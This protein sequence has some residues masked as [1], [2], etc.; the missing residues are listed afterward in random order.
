MAAS[1]DP[2]LTYTPLPEIPKI[3]SKARQVFESN[4]TLPISFRKAQ[5]RALHRCVVDNTDAFAQAVHKD[6]GKPPTEVQL[7][8]IAG[9]LK[10]AAEMHDKL[11]TLAKDEYVKVDLINAY[12]KVHIANQPYGVAT[13]IS[14]WNYPVVLALSPLIGAIAAGCVSVIKPSEV[15]PHTAAILGQVVPEY[16]DS[17]IVYF[18]QGAVAETTA[19]LAERS[20]VILYTGNTAV[21]KIVMSAAAKYL[22]P[23]ILELGGKSPVIL[24]EDSDL[25]IA[26]RRIMW[27]KVLNAGQT[28]IAPDYVLCPSSIRDTFVSEC[29]KAVNDFLGKDH[30]SSPD[31]TKIVNKHHFARLSKLLHRQEGVSTSKIAFGGKLD[32]NTRWMQP[33]V[34]VGVKAEDPLMEGEI[35]GPILPIVDCGSVDEAI[36]FV[37]DRERPLALYVFTK[38]QKI[39]DRVKR[40]TYSGGFLAN[41]VIMHQVPTEL[42]FG[43]IGP[44]GMGAYTGKSSYYAFTHRKGSMIKAQAMEATNSLRYPPYT[45]N[46][47]KILAF[48]LSAKPTTDTEKFLKL[49]V[50]YLTLT[51]VAFLAYKVC[52]RDWKNLLLSVVDVSKY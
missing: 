11:D 13:I 4:L 39:I 6:L 52:G 16:V 10:E 50:Y 14:P 41:D 3:V 8:E 40:S 26:A 45:E 42:P 28:C 7:A 15:T 19:L 1:L 30:E 35:F 32:E 29:A 51:S 36:K 34:V 23:V 43:G 12:D 22:T 48:L 21:G 5:L 9:L 18:V 17:R 27:G 47:R 33:T 49:A 2:A 25:S 31:M 20:D 44:S 38:N 46:K 37:N 24:C